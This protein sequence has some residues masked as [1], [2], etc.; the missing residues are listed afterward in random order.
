MNLNCQAVQNLTTQSATISGTGDFIPVN[1][2]LRNIYGVTSGG[3]YTLSGTPVAGT[4]SP[5]QLV[6]DN[7]TN[8]PPN[9]TFYWVTEELD[10]DGITVLATSNQCQFTTRD[11]E[12]S[13]EVLGFSETSVTVRVCADYIATDQNLEMKYGSVQGG[14]YP[15]TGGSVPGTNTPGQ[16]AIFTVPLAPCE[17]I[18]FKGS[19]SNVPAI[20]EVDWTYYH[21]ARGIVGGETTEL[22]IGPESTYPVGQTLVDTDFAIGAGTWHKKT[23]TYPVPLG[24]TQL[25]FGFV[26][27]IPPTGSVGNFIDG[28]SIILRQVLPVPMVLGEQLINGSFEFPVRPNGTNAFIPEAP[29][30]GVGW[31][32][33]DPTGVLEYWMQ[34]F[35]GYSAAPDGG[36]QW[37]ELSAFNA[38]ELSQA[39]PLAILTADSPECVASTFNLVCEPPVHVEIG[40][41]DAPMKGHYCGLPEGYSVQFQFATNPLG[42]F[43]DAGPVIF[44]PAISAT[45]VQVT[46]QAAALDPNTTYYFR[47]VARDKLQNIIGVSGSC[48][49]T[50]LDCIQWCGGWHLP[51]DCVVVDPENGEPYFN[52]NDG[53]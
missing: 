43:F 18:Y 47:I 32:T 8:L 5:G 38:S 40:C 50:T 48:Q 42:P 22:R 30:P 45:D 33:T 17:V 53:I 3:P 19:V 21:G 6:S 26:A 25:H 20:Y 36:R 31:N 46:S 16:C 1:H 24:I 11:Y 29:N 51:Q 34:G 15:L 9:T 28:C 7:V 39:V 44:S 35:L 27:T 10:T 49:F 12:T 13:C 41:T 37:V 4:N 52:C 23:G 2:F 14:P